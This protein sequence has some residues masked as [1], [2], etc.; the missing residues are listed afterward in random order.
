[1]FELV[2]EIAK[3]GSH[4]TVHLAG[5]DSRFIDSAPIYTIDDESGVSL[6]LMLNGERIIKQKGDEAGSVILRGYGQRYAG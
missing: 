2:S 1:M 3:A 5:E 6:L 4:L